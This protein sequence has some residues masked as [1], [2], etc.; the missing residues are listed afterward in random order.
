MNAPPPLVLSLAVALGAFLL[1]S[2]PFGL[3]FVRLSTG[4][5][6][7]EVGSGNIGATNALRAGG[8]LVGIATLLA[9][10]GK[11]ALAVGVTWLLTGPLLAP[12]APSI[13]AIAAVLGHCYPP[14]LRFAGG[15]GVATALGVL[16]VLAPPIAGLA[17]LAFAA[18]FAVTRKSS[19]GSLAAVLVAAA[20]APWLTRSSDDRW[21]V[22]SIALVVIVR[23]ADNLK[24]LFAGNERGV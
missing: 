3:L 21:A 7:R 6:V 16:L 24:R 20:A 11:G 4:R 19:V 8:R 5:D 23:H 18:L 15:K 1:G 14:W 2:I 17:V 12:D 10:A 9:D 22:L 13:A